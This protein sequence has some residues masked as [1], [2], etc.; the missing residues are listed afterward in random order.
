MGNIISILNQKG[1][2]GKTTTTINVAVYLAKTGKKVL[3]IDFDPQGNATSG[4]GID[5]HHVELTSYDCLIGPS[6]VD[7]IIQETTTPNLYVIPSNENLASAEVELA[8]LK[9]REHLLVNKI[10]G[11][12]FDF[13]IIDCPPSL[14]LLTINALTSSS[15]LIIPVQAEYYAL[16]GLSQLIEVFQRMRQGLNSNLELLGVLVTMYDSRTSLSEQVYKELIKHF[17]DKLFKTVIPRNVRLAEAPSY[18]KSIADYDKWSKG[19]RA[20]KQLSKEVL[21]RVG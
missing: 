16:E 9:D 6:S 1:G 2:V 12:Q 14:G 15:H 3:I 7:R 11:L 20:Y 10:K 13:I 19:A 5:K 18:G 4:I 21:H 8:N 17:A